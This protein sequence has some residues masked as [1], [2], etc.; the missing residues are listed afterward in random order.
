MT[1]KLFLQAL[2]KFLLGVALVSLLIF[3]PAGG[4]GFFRPWLF[5]GILFL[6]MLGVGIVLMIKAP[7][8][9]RS[10]LEAKESRREQGLVVKLSGVMFLA[11]FLT[12]GFGYRFGWYRLPLWA[13][14]IAAGGFLIAYG[15]YAEVLRENTYLSR[16]VRVQEEQTLIDTGLYGLVRHPMYGATVLMFLSMPLVLGSV[17]AFL[18]FLP[19]PFLLA[20]RIR[21]EEALLEKEL[22]G[23]GEY[24]KRVKYRMIPFIW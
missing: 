24:K 6:P 21:D 17:Y 3:L 16:T 13:S 9:L 1:G 11:G 18:I 20:L 14:L 4:I 19:Y 5:L 2:G 23:Y 7:E 12:A 8:L 22:A 15:L 10:R